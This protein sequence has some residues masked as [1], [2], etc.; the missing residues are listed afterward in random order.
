MVLTLAQVFAVTNRSQSVNPA[1]A[2]PAGV[3]EAPKAAL[4]AVR[5]VAGGP[6]L[7]AA[8]PLDLTVQTAWRGAGIQPAPLCRDEVF[9]RRAYLDVIGTLPAAAE[10]R[11]F[12]EDKNPD[13]RS[14][15]IDKIGRAS[16]RERV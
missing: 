4:Q 12:L 8:G 11:T 13:K 2:V 1:S 10:V 14:L 7:V 9:I 16:C 3:S 15:L 5:P 6:G